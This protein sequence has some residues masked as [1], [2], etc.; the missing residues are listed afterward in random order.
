MLINICDRCDRQISLSAHLY[1]HIGR[2]PGCSR[3]CCRVLHLCMEGWQPGCIGCK[4]EAAGRITVHRQGAAFE[5]AAWEV[6]GT[7]STGLKE[8]RC[9]ATVDHHIAGFTGS[10][11]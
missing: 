9:I 7:A 8:R 6:L 11:R 1:L 5:V 10:S 2:G 3:Q 4:E